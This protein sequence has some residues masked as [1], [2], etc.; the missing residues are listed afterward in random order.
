VANDD[1]R[2]EWATVDANIVAEVASIC[3]EA[4]STGKIWP[5]K[6]A[7]F[8]REILAEIADASR[9]N[10]PSERI[11]EVRRRVRE[12]PSSLGPKVI[13]PPY[14]SGPKT[15]ETPTGWEPNWDLWAFRTRVSLRD[16]VALSCNIAPERVHAWPGQ[17]E[18]ERRK[19]IAV[20]RMQIGELRR[21]WTTHNMGPEADGVDLAEFGAWIEKLLGVTL[22]P[23]F[24]RPQT[25]PLAAPTAPEAKPLIQRERT[26]LLIIIAALAKKAGVDLARPTLAA[27]D[28]RRIVREETDV[29]IGET[30]IAGY[31]KKTEDA[32][33]RRKADDDE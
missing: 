20:D 19:D 11:A 21:V 30:T 3:D 32:I 14:G 1:E 31:V 2:N 24:P 6:R 29:S 18:Y 28:I 25:P 13:Q 15:P 5:A 8:R 16:A 23:R 22:H 26:N 17:Q 10:S 7:A 4:V 12:M 27:R 9:G 33:E